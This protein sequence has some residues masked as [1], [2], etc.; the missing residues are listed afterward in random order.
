M[1]SILIHYNEIALK[2]KNRIFFEQKLANNIKFA[3]KNISAKVSRLPGRILAEVSDEAAAMA[4]LG[5]IFGISS[6]S[7]AISVKTDLEAIK[8]GAAEI[9]KNQAGPFDGTQG[10][11]RGRTRK[12]F[13]IETRRAWKQFSLDSMAISREVGAYI[14]DNSRFKVDVKKPDI[15]VEI[16]VLKERSF[17]YCGRMRGAGGLPVGTAGRV[18]VLISGGIDSPV[19]SYYAMK[20]GC[21]ADFIHFHSYPYTDKASIEKVKELIKILGKYQSR[22][23]LYLAPIVDFQKDT[24]KKTESRLRVIL[25]RRLM[26]KVAQAVA[27]KSNLK[28]LVSGDNLGQ[29][30]S[31]TLENMGTIGNGIELPILRPLV[32][33]DKEEI[34][35]VAKKIGT[36]DISIEPHG[37]CCSVF[38]P[39]NP[40]TKTILS[41]IFKEE[42]KLGM[43]KWAEKITKNIE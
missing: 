34:I 35:A 32:G 22:P 15:T 42:K 18:L 33:F 6:Y 10:A 3:L 28:A 16:E 11:E 23:R 13:K 41:E 38:L 4:V 39:Q 37:D 36:Y 27:R 2:G 40:A 26:Y 12:T 1:K 24:V 43:D 5:N 19:A 30:A 31:Q 8:N 21:E 14:L 20:R 9:I 29:V 25:Y 7:P 17:I